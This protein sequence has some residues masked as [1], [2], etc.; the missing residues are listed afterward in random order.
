MFKKKNKIKKKVRLKYNGVYVFCDF[1]DEGI[2]QNPNHPYFNFNYLRYIFVDHAKV[3][4]I[5]YTFDY[6]KTYI[7]GD[8]YLKLRKIDNVK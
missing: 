8:D 5:F 4:H 3:R 1:L 6:G 7:V 2:E